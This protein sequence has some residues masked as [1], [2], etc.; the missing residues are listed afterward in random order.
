V[1]LDQITKA[2]VTEFLNET[3]MPSTGPAQ[4][5]ERFSA[6]VVISPQIDAAIDYENI[7]TG[8]GGDTGQDAIAILVNGELITDPDE[9]DRLAS[10]GTTLDVNYIFVQAETSTSFS[11][12]KVGQIAYGVKD[13]FSDSPTLE[14]NEIVT[15]AAE[16]SQ[17]VLSNARL[18]RNGNPTCSV[19]YVTAGRWTGDSDLRAR[20]DSARSDIDELNLFSR[21]IFAPL[22]AREVQRRYQRLRTGAEREFTFPNRIALPEIGHVSESH[23]GYVPVTDLLSI[24]TDDDGLL[25]S[26][27]FYENVRDFQGEANPVNAEI[28]STLA[29]DR[30]SQFPLMNNGVTIIAKSVRQ[31][32]TKFVIR[33][34]QVV[35]GCQTCNVLWSRREQLE[36]TILVPLRLISTDDEDVIV[37][38]IRATNRQTEVKEEQFFA[39]SDYL[40]QLELYFE[41]TPL[42]R[43][44]YL[45]RRLKQHA[46]AP[47]ERTRVVPFNNLVRSFASIILSEPHRATRNYKQ[48]LERIPND[49]LNP[50]HKPSV[51]LAA[52]SSL[53]RLEFLFRNGV[54]DRRF[55]S[56]KYHFLLAS[57]LIV[58]PEIPAF[59]NS[60]EADSWAKDLIDVYWDAPRAEALFRTVAADITA[61][62]DGDLSRDRIRTQPFTEQVLSHYRSRAEA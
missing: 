56:A 52:A 50:S 47:V 60:N 45:E 1:A 38:I 11:T 29:G 5:F 23:L 42:D 43:R 32:G 17:K 27:A 37:D 61:L 26:T 20:V 18:F 7:M 3:G 22:D 34:F 33:D 16:I 10:S 59:L 31:T 21:V 28:A 2:L 35:N 57:R 48:L 46:N 51:Y 9:I 55:T 8:A 4:D 39:T 30:R 15:A 25:M 44:L 12:S 36:E 40:K 53:Y 24:L 58:K 62:A 49:I 41:S 19:Y 13:F 14:R 54:L 6:Y